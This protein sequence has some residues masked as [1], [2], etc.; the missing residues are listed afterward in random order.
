[1]FCNFAKNSKIQNGRHFWRE[2]FVL[3]I[4]MATLQ[5][6]PV[7]KN[8]VEIALSSRVFEIYAFL[9]FAIFAKNSKIKNGRHFW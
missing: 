1:M 3:K 6:Y 7:V 4:G 9:C 2:I 5:R 8:F